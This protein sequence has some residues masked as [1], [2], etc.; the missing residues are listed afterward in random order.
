MCPCPHGF[1][2]EN[3]CNLCYGGQNTQK[4][5]FFP[6]NKDILP[7]TKEEIKKFAKNLTRGKYRKTQKRR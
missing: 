3:L 4:T 7:E 5:E 6:Q 2:N 1:D